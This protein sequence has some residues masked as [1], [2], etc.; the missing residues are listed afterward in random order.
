MSLR[1]QD[2]SGV[3][4]GSVTL[5]VQLCIAVVA[6]VVHGGNHAELNVEEAAVERLKST[7]AHSFAGLNATPFAWSAG[8][9]RRIPLGAS[10]N[11]SFLEV[12]WKYFF[13]VITRKK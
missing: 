11:D 7:M 1:A 10:R 2:P 6:E 5:D 12:L 3:F 13:K 9:H 4:D 8:R